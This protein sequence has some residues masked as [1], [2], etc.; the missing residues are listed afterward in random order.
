ME[1]SNRQSYFDFLRG[2]AVLLV[3]GIHTFT[4]SPFDGLGNILQIGMREAINFAVPLFLTISGFFI[5]K[6][7][8]ANNSDYF[9][10]L[11]RQ[12][13]R[14]YVPAFLWSIPMAIFG[15]L[16]G[17][18]VASS[19]GKC[20]LCMIFGPYYFIV[21]IIQFYLLH[22]V[23]KRLCNKLIG[24]AFLL[25]T[26]M[27]SLFVFN[28]IIYTEQQPA[29]L[30]VG[31]CV[32][33]IVFYYIGVYLSERE[34]NYSLCWP[35]LLLMFGMITQ[36]FE[37]KY[38]MSCERIGIGIKISSW[39]YSAG[40]VLL[41]FSKKIEALVNKQS[42]VYNS[43]VHLGEM[44]FGVY[45]T[46]VYFLVIRESIMNTSSWSISFVFVALATTLFVVVLK[47][48]LPTNL[49]RLLGLQ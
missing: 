15:V 7:R 38:L 45:L 5:G 1:Q 29:V 41:L 36:M 3:I 25:L 39:L 4:I 8:I 35:L 9:C 26:N 14:V 18:S 22:P 27:T 6:R 46:H 10:F 2:I 32:Y 28:Y 21:L 11:K 33:W 30:S 19:I 12:L 37:T 31:P 48:L 42:K 13:P 20:F 34:R 23:V 17:Q 40:V 24:G 43:I 49:W 16:H 47:K 44:S